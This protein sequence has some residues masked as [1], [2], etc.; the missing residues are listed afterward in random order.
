[1][2][3]VCVNENVAF[4]SY[5]SS[6]TPLLPTARAWSTKDDLAEGGP[7]AAAVAF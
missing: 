1:M 7:R 2:F 3:F 6:N 5:T 4:P